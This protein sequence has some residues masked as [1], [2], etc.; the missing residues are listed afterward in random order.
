ME[1]QILYTQVS[2]E[3]A[4]HCHVFEMLMYA[5]IAELNQHLERPLPE[6]FQQ[7]WIHSIIAMQGP[8]DRHLEL[9]YV[10]GEAI[11]FLYGKIDHEDHKG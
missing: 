3:N 2:A 11:G 4:E 9:C 10:D 5:Y 1:K 6:P 8:C 7:K